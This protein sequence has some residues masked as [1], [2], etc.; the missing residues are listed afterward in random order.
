[1]SAKQHALSY[2]QKALLYIIAYHAHNRCGCTVEP[3]NKGH[4]GDSN[5]FTCFVLCI[6]IYIYIEVVLFS[7]VINVPKLLVL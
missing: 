4:V 6:Y 2:F 5:K 3:L 7:E 1:M